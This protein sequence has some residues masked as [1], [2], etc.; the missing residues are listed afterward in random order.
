LFDPSTPIFRTAQ[1]DACADA[2]KDRDERAR[3]EKSDQPGRGARIREEIDR[4]RRKD[5]R[6]T[7]ER[8][9]RGEYS[10]REARCDA[11]ATRRHAAPAEREQRGREDECEESESLQEQIG[12]QRSSPPRPVRDLL[13]VAR[14]VE[15]GVARVVRDEAQGDEY[16]NRQK[17][18]GHH[19]FHDRAFRA[20]AASRHTERLSHFAGV[21]RCPRS[22]VLCPLSFVLSGTSFPEIFSSATP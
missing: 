1:H 12:H 19:L 20:R 10:R 4:N 14:D 6:E 22:F 13:A 5:R 18:E 21:V 17:A 7:T 3:N 8:N 2:I 16:S 11:Q 9:E 15:R